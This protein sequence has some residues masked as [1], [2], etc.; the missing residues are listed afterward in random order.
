MRKIRKGINRWYDINPDIARAFTSIQTMDSAYQHLVAEVILL[1][2][3]RIREQKVRNGEL[4]KV[5]AERALGLLKSQ[6]KRRLYDQDKMLHK[7]FNKLFLLEDKQR[8]YLAKRLCN[9]IFYMEEYIDACYRMGRPEDIQEAIYLLKIAID[10][11]EDEGK[12]YLNSL[13]LWD[14]DAVAQHRE[15]FQQQGNNKAFREPVPLRIPHKSEE[16]YQE[17]MNLI[18][19]DEGLKIQKRQNP[20]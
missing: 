4:L 3:T 18:Q 2:S 11:G 17:P 6:S 10:E 5:G 12:E 7:A 20:L 1:L 19:D 8:A 14:D 9:G 15:Q 13:G 16:V